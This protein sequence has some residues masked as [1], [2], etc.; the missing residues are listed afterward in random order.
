[1][2][3]GGHRAAN[4]KEEK[5]VMEMCKIYCLDVVIERG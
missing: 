4:W 1:M 3:D 2:A 5:S